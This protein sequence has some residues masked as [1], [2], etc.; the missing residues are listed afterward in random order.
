MTKFWS[1]RLK[2]SV[3]EDFQV[4]ALKGQEYIYLFVLLSFLPLSS[5]NLDEMSGTPAAIL[6]HKENLRMTEQE[7]RR[8]PV[9]V[10]LLY[11]SWS[12]RLFCER[13]KPFV[14]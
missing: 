9:T 7:G 4:S 6:D 3:T 1:K 8:I 13:R 12:C 11:L 2:Q 10:E 5:W 14:F